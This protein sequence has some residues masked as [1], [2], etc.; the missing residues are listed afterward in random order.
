MSQITRSEIQFEEF[1]STNGVPFQR[2]QVADSPR[3]DYAV[4]DGTSWGPILFEVKELT[5]D[6]DFGQGQSSSRT[7]GTHI[8]SKISK[9]RRQVQFGATRDIPSILL[10]YNA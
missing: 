3:P 10:I 5:E 1:L 8:R 4:G 9:S 2:V 7:V 6:D